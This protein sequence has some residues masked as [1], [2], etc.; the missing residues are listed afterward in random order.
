MLL[1]LD[2]QYPPPGL[3][4]SV[5]DVRAEAADWWFCMRTSGTEAGAGDLLRLYVEAFEDRALMETYPP[6]TGPDES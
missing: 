1:E 4:L 6:G 2:R 5:S 3:E